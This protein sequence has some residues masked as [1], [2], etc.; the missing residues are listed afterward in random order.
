MFHHELVPEGWTVNQHFYKQVLNHLHDWVRHSRR[1]LW[2]N[3]SW[4][5]HHNNMPTNTML[6][7]RQFLANNHITALDHPPYSTDLAPS[8][9]WLF[10]RLQTVLKGTHFP[11]VEEIKTTVTS[12]L[13]YTSKRRTL[14]SVS[15]GGINSG[16]GL[17]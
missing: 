15:V 1:A 17:L 10:P 7:V 4:L 8:N 13:K 3:K 12:E 2:R 11:S 16:G 5:L 14:P 9:F 6:S